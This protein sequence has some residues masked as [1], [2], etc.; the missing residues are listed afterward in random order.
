MRAPARGLVLA[1]VALVL[2]GC[3]LLPRPSEPPIEQ[4]PVGVRVNTPPEQLQV[5][6]INQT[7]IPVVLVVNGK[8]REMAP[9]TSQDLGVAELGPLPWDFQV[10]TVKGRQLLRDTLDAGVVSRTNN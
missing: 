1:L 4:L 5:K 7:T 9:G 10:T 2:A 8:A 3:S 6:A